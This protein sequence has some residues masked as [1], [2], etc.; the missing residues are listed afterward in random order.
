M[1]ARRGGSGRSRI[2]LPLPRQA[3]FRVERAELAQQRARLGE[4]GCR[5]RIEEGEGGRVGDAPG[6]AVEQQAGEVGGEDLRPG[7]RLAARPSA[8]SS[9]SRIADAR[10]GAAGAAAPLVGGGARHAHR[11]QPRQAEGGLEARHAREPAIDDDAH[12]LDGERGLGDGG[13]QHHLA[14]PGRGRL[15]GAVLGLLLHGAVERGEVDRGIARCARASSSLGP[16]DLALARAGRRG[17]S[18]AR[19]AARAAPRRP[20]RPRSG[21]AGRGRDSG[22]RPGRRGPRCRSPAHRRA[23]R[24]TRAP[25]SVADM[26][27]SRRSSRSPPCAS[28][29]RAR[30]QI[31]VERALVELVEQHGGD[32]GELGIVEDHAGEHAL[33]D[34][35]D[36][37]ASGPPSSRGARAGRRSR[38][39][40]RRASRAMRSAAARAASRR[41][42]QHEDLAARRPGLVQQRQRHARRLARAG[43]RDEHGRIAAPRAPPAARAGPR[44]WAA[45]YRS[46]AC[47]RC[48]RAGGGR[49]GRRLHGRRHA[50]VLGCQPHLTG[51]SPWRRTGPSTGTS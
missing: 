44:R 49:Q 31:G 15:D 23:S 13:G 38:R 10:L 37:R 40:A 26:T 9:H 25:S 35:L 43:R 47:G 8:A 11:L 29:A 4:R 30:P 46:G 50:S 19:R 12:A 3:A 51:G 28:S 6:G 48:D 2:A 7:E 20:P 27:S 34:D 1:R 14:P 41:G 33:G 21:G 5:R 32:A 45:A 36:A 16:A 42:S 39:R 24:A 18:P 17:W 22:S